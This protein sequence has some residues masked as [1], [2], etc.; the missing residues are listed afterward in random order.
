MDGLSAAASA[1]A[2]VQAA[3]ALGVVARAFY[4]TFISKDNQDRGTDTAKRVESIGEFIKKIK[5]LQ[6]AAARS[7][8]QP[9]AANNAAGPRSAVAAAAA[10]GTTQNAASNAVDELGLVQTLKQCED[11]LQILAK[12]VQKMTAPQG[13]NQWKQF[14]KKI[15]LKLN[16]PEFAYFEA[17]ITTLLQKL[18]LL[19]VLASFERSETSIAQSHVARN[20][21]SRLLQEMEQRGQI[22]VAMLLEIR[23]AVDQ[24]AL[25]LEKLTI[26]PHLDRTASDLSG[27]TTA[28][29][30]EPMEVEHNPPSAA[31]LIL[32]HPGY[33]VRGRRSEAARISKPIL[34][35]IERWADPKDQDASRVYVRTSR[36]DDNAHDLCSQVVEELAVAQGSLLYYNGLPRDGPPPADG[37]Y[38]MP[39]LIWWLTVQMGIPVPHTDGHMP[40]S[41]YQPDINLLVDQLEKEGDLVYIILYL[42]TESCQSDSDHKLYHSLIDRLCAIQSSQTRLL[43]FSNGKGDL[44]LAN[45]G[46]NRFVIDDLTH[47]EQVLLAEWQPQNT[48][49]EW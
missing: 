13:A 30:G 33:D 15:R 27:A 3:G 7:P 18:T 4:D 2:I 20:E 34:D 26:A 47:Q 24:Q 31:P 38:T 46:S 45:F 32:K 19:L 42:P 49:E 14:M 21:A 44:A 37:W 40:S 22:Q 10:A 29:T 43:L 12:K 11:Q 6:L 16:E 17:I 28:V 9:V 36:S 1:I 48:D 39:H 8:T 23:K 41:G 25:A 5:E 35:W